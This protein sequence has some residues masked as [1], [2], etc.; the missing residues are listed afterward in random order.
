[1]GVRRMRTHGKPAVTSVVG[2]SVNKMVLRSMATA[3]MSIA[4]LVD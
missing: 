4:G 2:A 1:M 3:E